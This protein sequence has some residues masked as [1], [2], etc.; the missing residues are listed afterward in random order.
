M[1]A[2]VWTGCGGTP[3][4]VDRDRGL[5]DSPL[6]A[7]LDMEP[8]RGELAVGIG[9]LKEGEF[10]EAKGAFERYVQAFPR[11]AMG[12]YHLGLVAVEQSDRRAAR[13]HFRRALDLNPQLH[14]A[15]SMLGAM[16]VEDGEEIAALEV[17]EQAHEIAPEDPRVLGNLAAALLRRGRWTEAIEMYQEAVALAPSHG[18]LLYDLALALRDRHEDEAAL[19]RL[20]EALEVRPQFALARAARVACLQDLGRLDEAVTYAEATLDELDEPEPDNQ[21]VLGRALAGRGDLE[22]ALDATRKALKLK[23]DYAPAQFALAEILDHRGAKPEAL[24]AYRRFLDNP[25]RSPDEARRARERRKALQDGTAIR[26]P[27]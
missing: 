25:A 22:G 21:L 14:G 2:L 1:T 8:V 9:L 26:P 10:A 16:L 23:E 17:L 4:R 12:W 6:R 19:A 24:E 11:S 27:R 15:A 3:K 20:D 7:D 5:S 18:T 13:S